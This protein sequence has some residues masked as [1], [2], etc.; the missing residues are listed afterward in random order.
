MSR[1]TLDDVPVEDYTDKVYTEPEHPKGSRYVYF[2]FVD[3]KKMEEVTHKRHIENDVARALTHCDYTHVE[4]LFWD[5][6]RLFRIARGTKVEEWDDKEIRSY[7]MVIRVLFTDDQVRKMIE[8]C[9]DHIG[10]EYDNMGYFCFICVNWCY[11]LSCGRTDVCVNR[12][13]YTCTRLIGGSL[14]YAGVVTISEQDL[15]RLDCTR[16]LNF[17]M[18]KKPVIVKNIKPRADLGMYGYE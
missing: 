8:Y 18:R 12:E 17:L 16:I 10:A 7:H 2:L 14:R 5:V 15:D 1:L 3:T 13:K 6:N 4:V 9:T 11:W